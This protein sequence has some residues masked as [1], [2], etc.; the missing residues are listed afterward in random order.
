MNIL[1][2]TDD[3]QLQIYMHPKRQEILYQLS[4]QGPMTAKMLSTSLAMTPSSA[5]HHLGK[6]QELGVVAVDHQE[7]INGIT[8]TYYR[9]VRVTVSFGA[10]EEQS[11]RLVTDFLSKQVH[12]GLEEHARSFSDEQGHFQADQLSGVVHLSAEEADRLYWMI[13]TFID[14]REDKRE[15]TEP[16]VYSLVAYHA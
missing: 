10:L 8:A 11:R 7:V 2:L 15:G 12:D 14:E 3:K 5:K 4:I 6:L 1:T 16:F 13:R 9:K